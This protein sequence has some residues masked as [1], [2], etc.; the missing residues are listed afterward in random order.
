VDAR[1]QTTK[2]LARSLGGAPSAQ[3]VGGVVRDSMLIATV[4][5]VFLR[6]SD[7]ASESQCA[8]FLSRMEVHFRCFAGFEAFG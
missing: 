6:R 1:R 7:R 8:R 3:P 4:L 5:R 2:E